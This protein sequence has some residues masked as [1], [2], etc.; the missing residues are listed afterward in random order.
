MLFNLTFTF[1]VTIIMEKKN[2]TIKM[3]KIKHFISLYMLYLIK[4]IIVSCVQVSECGWQPRRAPTLKNL[5]SICKNMHQWLKQDQRN[6]CIIHCLVSKHTHTHSPFP[7]MLLYKLP[8]NKLVHC[9][10]R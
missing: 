8:T 3:K 4:L 7:A 10:L 9:G 1:I 2:S 6:I 5:Y